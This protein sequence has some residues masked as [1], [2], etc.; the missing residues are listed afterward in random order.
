[1]KEQEAGH[2]TKEASLISS[3]A[4]QPAWRLRSELLHDP[5]AEGYNAAQLIH[6]THRGPAFLMGTLF[7]GGV[8]VLP[9]STGHL[10]LFCPFVVHA[11]SFTSIC[12]FHSVSPPEVLCLMALGLALCSVVL[13]FWQPPGLLSPAWSLRLLATVP[14]IRAQYS[15]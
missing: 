14:W 3:R 5:A 7:L 4:R 13:L 8:M 10:A 9:P 1:M 11:S 2:L 15:Q 6:P 12:T